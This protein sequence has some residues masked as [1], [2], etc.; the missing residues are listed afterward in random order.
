[1]R[2]VVLA[3]ALAGCATTQQP[4]LTS[5]QV[6]LATG[7]EFEA[8]GQAFYRGCSRGL[9]PTPTCVSWADFAQRFKP[10]YAAAV[11]A[12][13]MGATLA[14]GDGGADWPALVAELADLS[15]AL[16]AAAFPGGAQ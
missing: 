5:G 1:M 3:L 14:T 6:L 2:A 13:G 10:S 12:W 7:R 15:V 9:I 8:V 16:S 4:V 11:A